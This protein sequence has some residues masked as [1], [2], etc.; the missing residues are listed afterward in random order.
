MENNE[1][2]SKFNKLSVKLYFNIIIKE[3]VVIIDALVLLA[4]IR[5]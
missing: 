2:V 4:N 3:I 5:K 1:E